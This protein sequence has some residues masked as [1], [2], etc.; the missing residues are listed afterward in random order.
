LD[1]LHA[2]EVQQHHHK[3]KENIAKAKLW[4]SDRSHYATDITEVLDEDDAWQRKPGA[5]TSLAGCVLQLP[6]QTSSEESEK[7]KSSDDIVSSQAQQ[8][9]MRTTEKSLSTATSGKYIGTVQST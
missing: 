3:R 4:Y 9:K 2:T 6:T 5:I 7:I 1:Q 8:Y